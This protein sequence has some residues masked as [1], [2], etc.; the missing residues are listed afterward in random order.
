MEPQAEPHVDGAEQQ[1]TWALQQ[2]AAGWLQQVEAT[3]WHVFDA[4]AVCWQLDVWLQHLVLGALQH[5]TFCGL[6]QCRASAV[7]LKAARTAKVAHNA[8]SFRIRLMLS[9]FSVLM[10][11]PLATFHRGERVLPSWQHC[12]RRFASDDPWTQAIRNINGRRN[13]SDC[14][15]CAA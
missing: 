3:V 14:G 4:Q 13:S 9:P 12:S 7:L 6:Q 10:V 5:L 2:L 8:T 11:W 15:N 1:L